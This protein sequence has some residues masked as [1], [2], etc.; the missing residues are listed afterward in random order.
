MNFMIII[1]MLLA[2]MSAPKLGFNGSRYQYGLYG[3]LSVRQA[4][5]INKILKLKCLQKY[6][7]F[8]WFRPDLMQ[9]TPHNSW[10]VRKGPFSKG[11]LLTILILFNYYYINKTF[12]GICSHELNY[13]GCWPLLYRHYI[14]LLPPVQKWGCHPHDGLNKNLESKNNRKLRIYLIYL[15]YIWFKC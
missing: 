13:Y 11:P 6:G 9:A 15:L 1:S 10:W 12:S 3:N 8:C 14:I 4:S 5:I 2:C 7:R